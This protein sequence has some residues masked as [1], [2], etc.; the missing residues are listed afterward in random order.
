MSLPDSIF[1]PTLL[2]KKLPPP[3]KT[4]DTKIQYNNKLEPNKVHQ[5]IDSKIDN[6]QRVFGSIDGEISLPQFH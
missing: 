3:N 1:V 5:F 2:L 4:F 6:I